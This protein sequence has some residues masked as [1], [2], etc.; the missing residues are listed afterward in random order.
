[1]PSFCHDVTMFLDEKTEKDELFSIYYMQSRFFLLWIITAW[2][3]SMISSNIDFHA[4]LFFV[5]C[6]ILTL[7]THSAKNAPLKPIQTAIFELTAIKA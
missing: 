4:L 6:Q 1:M 2:D 7:S 5:Q 3:M